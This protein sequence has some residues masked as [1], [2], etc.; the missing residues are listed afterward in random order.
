MTHQDGASRAQNAASVIATL[1]A[2]N[3]S[4]LQAFGVIKSEDLLGMGDE[5]WAHL[6]GRLLVALLE[7][8][9]PT[10]TRSDARSTTAYQSL[11][12]LSSWPS[13]KEAMKKFGAD[14]RPYG[15]NAFANMLCN[16][17]DSKGEST[18]AWPSIEARLELLLRFSS[19]LQQQRLAQRLA[20]RL[21][22]SK[23]VMKV[24]TTTDDVVAHG[25]EQDSTATAVTATR[26]TSTIPAHFTET[27]RN[28]VVRCHEHL[29][30]DYEQRLQC[31]YQRLKIL[32]ADYGVT[33]TASPKLFVPSSLSSR[34]YLQDKLAAPASASS[35]RKSDTSR[36]LSNLP[37]PNHRAT[38]AVDRGG[39]LDE[40]ECRGLATAVWKDGGRDEAPAQ[41]GRNTGAVPRGN[42]PRN[43]GRKPKQ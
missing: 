40:R 19:A 16:E 1:T 12:A 8:A 31:M 32:E 26:T 5:E 21:V 15:V 25:S 35:T 27:Q 37:R 11:A 6:V 9:D 29:R 39:R 7:S 24:S 30:A 42:R 38:G 17:G 4:S 22:Q 10:L 41:K 43:R 28:L 14:L 33:E 36:V 2:E 18:S 3:L 13:I 23:S 34:E 20:Q